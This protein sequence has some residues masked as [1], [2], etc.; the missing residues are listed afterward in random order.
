MPVYHANAA[1][2]LPFIVYEICDPR[3]GRAFYVG[4]TANLA[5]RMSEHLGA[6]R[7]ATTAPRIL[8]LLRADLVPVFRIICRAATRNEA[9]RI[10]SAR[11]RT[12]DAQHR[13][14][15]HT[16]DPSDAPAA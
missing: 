2:G 5:R 10:E 4:Q 7:G 13:H 11:R 16:G 8:S 1:S 9:I 12:L 14:A 15:T 3:S 6:K